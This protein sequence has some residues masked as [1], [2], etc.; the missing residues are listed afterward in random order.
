[1]ERIPERETGFP[2]S[3]PG[4]LANNNCCLSECCRGVLWTLVWLRMSR[5]NTLGVLD[6]K[7]FAFGPFFA[8]WRQRSSALASKQQDSG[9]GF[10]P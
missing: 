9:L 10:D 1:M 4:L 2:W 6:L 7:G 3:L 8:S 5:I